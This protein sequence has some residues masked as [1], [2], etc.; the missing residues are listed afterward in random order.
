MGK[1]QQVCTNAIILNN[2]NEILLVKRALN[3]EFL[4]GCWELPG[5]GTNY[6]EI[7]QEALK[8]EIKEEC[9]LNVE[10][11]EPLTVNTYYIKDIQRV[12]ITFLC[13]IIDAQYSVELSHEHIDYKWVRKNELDNIE[14]T[15]YIK[16]I[17]KSAERT[18]KH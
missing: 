18:L 4:P 7:A 14:T 15:E 3:D 10:I 2:N 6:G 13:M 1:T 17:I 16:G 12:E 5:G 8:R 11:R 9:G